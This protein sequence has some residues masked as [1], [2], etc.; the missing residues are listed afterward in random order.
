M[1]HL[2][3]A[4]QNSFQHRGTPCASNHFFKPIG[5]VLS[6]LV[7]LSMLA[8]NMPAGAG[9]KKAETR[10]QVSAIVLTMLK[11]KVTSQQS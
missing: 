3:K 7:L 9:E 6:G 10:I 8:V 5:R 1:K 4:T 2:A 11:I